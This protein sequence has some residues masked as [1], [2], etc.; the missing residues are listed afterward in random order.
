MNFKELVKIRFY[1]KQYE[2]ISKEGAV[3]FKEVKRNE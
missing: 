2:E 1:M 3:L